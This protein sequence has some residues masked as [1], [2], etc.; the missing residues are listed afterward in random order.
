MFGYLTLFFLKN[1]MTPIDQ[2][3]KYQ[4]LHF[5]GIYDSHKLTRAKK[6]FVMLFDVN[7]ASFLKLDEFYAVLVQDLF[8][9]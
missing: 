4:S 7:R 9:Q 1:V 5:N 3:E 2:A 8:R 6:C